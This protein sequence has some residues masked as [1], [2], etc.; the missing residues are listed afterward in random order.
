MEAKLLH[1][2]FSVYAQSVSQLA[3]GCAEQDGVV[4]IRQVS[5]VTAKVHSGDPLTEEM[6]SVV[7]WLGTKPACWGW[8]LLLTAGRARVSKI[9]VRSVPG[10][11]NEVMPLWSPQTSLSP[12]RFQKGKMT[13]LVQSLGSLSDFHTLVENVGQPLDN[14]VRTR[15]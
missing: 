13:P 7:E 6:W 2:L 3:V 14:A 5:Q 15:F 4:S 12:L 10:M 1:C 9:V 11:D 8:R